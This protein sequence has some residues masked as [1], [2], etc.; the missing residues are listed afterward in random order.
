MTG[1]LF[2]ILSHVGSNVVLPGFEECD[3]DKQ[4]LFAHFYVVGC[5]G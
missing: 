4:L 3:V 1:I 5:E 2:R